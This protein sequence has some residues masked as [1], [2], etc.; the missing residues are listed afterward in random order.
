[1]SRD[2]AGKKILVLGGAFQHLKLIKTAREMGIITYVT[3]YLQ[4]KY[5]PAKQL[6]DYAYP[7]N[8]TEIDK[9]VSL[10]VQE[11]IDGI[12]APYLDVT[13]IPYCIL[14]E[15]LGVPC[16][17]NKEQHRILTDKNLFKRFCEQ[18]GVD[19][20]P[21]YHEKDIIDRDRCNKKVEYPII[22]KPCDSRGSRGQTICYSRDEAIAAI[23]FAKTESRSENIVIEK[24]LVSKN[25]LQL[26][27]IVIE[28]EPILVRVEDRYVGEKNSGLD[29]LAIASIEPSIFEQEYR[30]KVNNK[31]I[32]MIRSLGLNYSPV[33]IQGLIDGEKVRF[34][35]PGIRMP[36]DEYDTIYKSV[37]GIDL[38]ELLIRFSLTGKISKEIG[39]KINNIRIDKATA[40]IYSAVRP[41]KIKKIEGIE[42][43]KKNPCILSVSQMYRE[44]DIVDLHNNVQQR[45]G[46]FDIACKDFKQLKNTIDWLFQT[47]HV[48][49]EYG[50]DMIFAK[51]DTN[52]LEKYE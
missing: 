14:C 36:G 50:E 42:K 16:F 48:F 8:I 22:V 11:H 26:V 51:F 30:N 44:G 15:R 19:V 32:P 31:V 47:L 17:G 33:F 24:Y 4:T 23:N 18:H 21:Y 35:D 41:G 29:K 40:M 1:M 7:Y 13:Q 27:Y 39:K 43:I 28:G 6:A 38:T 52:I 2:L 45:F 25:D 49:D 3:D 46:E 12:I 5:S 20:I 9:L 37:T 34:Y 10:C